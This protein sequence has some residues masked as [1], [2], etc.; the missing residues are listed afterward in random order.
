MDK[1][2]NRC[3]LE[4]LNVSQV[5][6][7]PFDIDF[8]DSDNVKE[9][10]PTEKVSE[11]FAVTR[12]LLVPSQYRDT[13]ARVS[14]EAFANGIPVIASKTGGVQDHVGKAG[15]VVEDFSNPEAWVT[16]LKSLDNAEVYSEYSRRGLE[17]IVED[18]S[19]SKTVD[20]FEALF[21]NLINGKRL[22]Q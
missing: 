15:L 22:E 6:W 2:L 8:S 3:A 21:K 20:Q 5:D 19:N 12:I 1:K 4:S 7:L 14:I 18:F 9:L 13:L 10:E 17:F 11:I 16:A